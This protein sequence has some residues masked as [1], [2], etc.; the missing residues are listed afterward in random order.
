MCVKTHSHRLNL[1]QPTTAN[2]S[3][4]LHSNMSVNSQVVLPH[5]TPTH[6][7][8][9]PSGWSVQFRIEG[10][11][12]KLRAQP[13]SSHATFWHGCILNLA[14]GV[15]VVVLF[16]HCLYFVCAFHLVA[17]NCIMFNSRYT[18]THTVWFRVCAFTAL[19]PCVLCIPMYSSC[20]L[21]F[22]F[23]LRPTIIVVT[24]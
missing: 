22:C 5:S 6:N 14:L 13:K 15:G 9:A 1:A 10:H 7:K 8:H 19:L 3:I 16:W 23:T 18:K 11:P 21:L 4:T 17:H 24:T 2:A 12:R 20:A